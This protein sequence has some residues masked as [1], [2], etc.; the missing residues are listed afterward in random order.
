V[1]AKRQEVAKFCARA[2]HVFYLRGRSDCSKAGIKISKKKIENIKMTSI[3]KPAFD[4]RLHHVRPAIPTDV[5]L[6]IPHSL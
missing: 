6:G 4:S 5:F 2:R 3:H 1:L